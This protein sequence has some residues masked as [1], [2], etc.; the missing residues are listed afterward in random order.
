MLN[1][2]FFD[3]EV[4]IYRIAGKSA[5]VMRWVYPDL[6][7]LGETPDSHTLV[8]VVQRYKWKRWKLS[9]RAMTLPHREAVKE[10]ACAGAFTDGTT[11]VYWRPRFVDHMRGRL[12]S[13]VEG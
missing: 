13:I 1:I 10:W 9:L 6:E 11:E 4:P 7:N 2:Y 12:M 5:E 3:G 8:T